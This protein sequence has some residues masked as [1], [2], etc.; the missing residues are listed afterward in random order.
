MGRTSN[1]LVP[2]DYVTVLGEIKERIR[3]AQYEA[4]RTVNRE[5]VS[6]Y[7]DIGRI[8]VERQQSDSWGKA[9]VETLAHDL[10]TEFPGMNGFS[11]RNIWRMRD[12]YIAYHENI[13]TDTTSD[14]N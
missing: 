12:F 11:P 14:R 1:A 6:L 5:L 13:K 9:I 3:S 10:Q 2:H 7:W 4:L 8:I